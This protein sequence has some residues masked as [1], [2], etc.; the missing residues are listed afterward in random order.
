MSFPTNQ[1]YISGNPLN[2]MQFHCIPRRILHSNGIVIN[3]SLSGRSIQG[4]NAG[5][6]ECALPP[7]LEWLRH[8]VMSQAM[9][10]LWSGIR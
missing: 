1:R 3:P 9:L 2:L 10:R 6:G 5:D 8:S 4:S 7:R